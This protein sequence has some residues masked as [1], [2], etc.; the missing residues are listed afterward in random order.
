MSHQRKIKVCHFSSVHSIIDTRVFYRECVSMARYFDVTLIAIGNFSG[1]RQGVNIIGLAKPK[2]RFQRIVGTIFKAFYLA[3]KQNAHIYHIHDA[4]MIPFGIVLSLLGKNVIYD[5]H[6]NTKF[7][8]LMKPWLPARK[9]LAAAYDLVLHL[10]SRFLYFI[11]VVAHERFLRVFHV[12]PNRYTIIQ[13]FADAKQMLS[14]KVDE[15]WNL[16]GNHIFYIGMIKD[17]YYD[18]GKLLDAIYI[19]KQE[20]FPVY[21]HCVGYYGSRTT[22][23]F[24]EHPHWN[25]VKEHFHFY[26]Y[27]DMDTGY[28]ISMQCKVGVCL[29]DQPEEMLVSHERKF[30]EYMAVSLPM[31]CCDSHIYKDVLKEYPVG[32][33][34]DIQNAEEVSR[35]L[36]RL[37]GDEAYYKNCVEQCRLAVVEKYNWESQ[38]Q[39]LK[40]VYI[41][42]TG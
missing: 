36:R 14:Y 9:L 31:I 28:R 39:V 30:F 41:N 11:P 2:N 22:H 40:Q 3:L 19:L 25:V 1:E 7:D 34:C 29:K 32:I 42:L 17:M 15:R 18:F 35:A 38:E 5:I 16:P 33:A 4:E 6:E 10:A 13:N 8:I 21:V 24:E 37:L 26:G 12:K 27:L 23:G 20:N